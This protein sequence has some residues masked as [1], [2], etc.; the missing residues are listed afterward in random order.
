[1]P[2]KVAAFDGVWRYDE[3]Q[4]ADRGTFISGMLR[5][6]THLILNQTPRLFNSLQFF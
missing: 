6:M 5:F 3:P 4:A 1:M 2:V